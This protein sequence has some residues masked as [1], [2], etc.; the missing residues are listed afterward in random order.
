MR[1][2]Q[3][4]LNVEPSVLFTQAFQHLA[5]SI[6]HGDDKFVIS[7]M[8]QHRVSGQVPGGVSSCR[9]I[10]SMQCLDSTKNLALL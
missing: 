6:H 4:I 3:L 10:K 7:F 9:Q 1:I 2:K 5:I 8:T